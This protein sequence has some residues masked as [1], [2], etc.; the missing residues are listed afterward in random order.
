MKNKQNRLLTARSRIISILIS[1]M[2]VAGG[3]VTLSSGPG[4][5]ESQTAARCWPVGICWTP[6]MMPWLKLP[7]KHTNMG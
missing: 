5:A 4:Y 1:G 6:G 3:F 2:L 7:K